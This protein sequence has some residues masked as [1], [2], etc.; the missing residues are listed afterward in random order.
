[1]DKKV[2]VLGMSGM[3]FSIIILCGAAQVQGQEKSQSIQSYMIKQKKLLNST[4]S[5]WDQF[6]KAIEDDTVIDITLITDLTLEGK[7]YISGKLKNIYDGGLTINADKNQLE[8]NADNSVALI[9]NCKIKS[10]EIYGLLWSPNK[11]VEVIYRN[12]DHQGNQMIYLPYDK[13]ILD[14]TVT[15]MSSAEEVF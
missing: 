5:N 8:I 11:G 12:V 7:V 14:G 3:L 4:V 9:E 1:M 10:T 13:L 6:K 15:S 2:V